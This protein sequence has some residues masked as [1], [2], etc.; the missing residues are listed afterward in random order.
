[1]TVIAI[2]F[3][4]RDPFE[5]ISAEYHTL[6]LTPTAPPLPGSWFIW[7]VLLFGWFDDRK[8]PDKP[9]KPNEPDQPDEPNQP[10]KETAIDVPAGSLAGFEK[11][12]VIAFTIARFSRCQRERR[13]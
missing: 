2:Y 9:N 12:F 4:G 10:I 1:M 8:K 5:G 6:G 13:W 11:C 7:F 3:V